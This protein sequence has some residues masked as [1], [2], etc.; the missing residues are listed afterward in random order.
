MLAPWSVVSSR[1]GRERLACAHLRNQGFGVFLPLHRRTAR[2]SRRL[3]TVL[4]PLFPGY[5]FVAF[6]GSPRLVRAIS[7]TRGVKQLLMCGERPSTLPAGFVE[8]LAAGADGDGVVCYRSQ[9]SA[10][11]TIEVAAGPFARQ[12]GELLSMDDRGRVTVLLELM[13][14]KVPVATQVSN[15]LPA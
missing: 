3:R 12:V 9:L 14:T 2:H 11:D 10:G 7:G 6:D 13:S 8:G 5:V 15:L 1:V 4:A